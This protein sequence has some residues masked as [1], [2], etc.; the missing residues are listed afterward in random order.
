MAE[1][2]DGETTTANWISAL[3]SSAVFE[4]QKQLGGRAVPTDDVFSG[5]LGVIDERGGKITSTA[6]ARAIDFPPMRLRG[7]L[8]V[9]QRILNIDG[10][11]VLTRDE[12]SD[13]IELDRNLLLKQFDLV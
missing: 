4:E 5:L 6:L 10:Y 1:T 8:A 7:M 12:A 2:E 9:A 11:S 13:T 3:L